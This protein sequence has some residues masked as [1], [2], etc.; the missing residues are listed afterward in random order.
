MVIEGRGLQVEYMLEKKYQTENTL[1]AFSKALE[2]GA[3]GIELDVFLTSDGKVVVCHDDEIDRNMDGLHGAW[4]RDD[5]VTQGRISEK[6]LAE[7]KKIDVGHG[8][9]IPT[10]EEVIT[11]VENYLSRNPS[12]KFIINIEIKGKGPIVD[13]VYKIIQETAEKGTNLKK[14]SFMINSFDQD[15]LSAMAK[16]DEDREMTKSLGVYTWTAF[17]SKDE[18][19]D[20]WLPVKRD[21]N[22]NIMYDDVSG[23]LEIKEEID[24]VSLRALVMKAK[25]E[26]CTAIDLVSSDVTTKAM[27]IASE[28]G[29]ALTA[30]TNALR[31]RAQEEIKRP[32]PQNASKTDLEIEQQEVAKLILLGRKF[33]SVP[34]YYKADDPGAMLSFREKYTQQLS[35]SLLEKP[36]ASPVCAARSL[37]KED[38]VPSITAP[39][40]PPKP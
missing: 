35:R 37:I 27:E 13:A 29:M 18:L 23:A 33:P 40:T 11:L 3:E 8:A 4:G 36:V 30:T 12:R 17:G 10:L 28:Y 6:P 34:I 19:G 2:D 5:P 22:G 31:A 24:E 16:L 7:V 20:S 15:A 14:Q 39:R 1:P 25:Q 9:K 32:V 38:E 26:G 21:P